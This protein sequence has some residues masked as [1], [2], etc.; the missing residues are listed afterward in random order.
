MEQENTAQINNTHI[1]EFNLKP[2]E[3]VVDV[4]AT[5]TTPEGPFYR[6]VADR[7]FSGERL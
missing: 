6:K 1:A 4:T 7:N 5:I 3:N 2:G